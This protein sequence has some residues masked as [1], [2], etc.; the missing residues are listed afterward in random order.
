MRSITLQFA[1]IEKKQKWD[2]KVGKVRTTR[3][4]QFK[5]DMDGEGYYKSQLKFV[6]PEDGFD[7]LDQ[8]LR[9]IQPGDNV[10]IMIESTRRDVEYEPESGEN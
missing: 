7:D 9:G 5:K 1:G 6:A 4:A 8:M 3:I 2:E 10:R